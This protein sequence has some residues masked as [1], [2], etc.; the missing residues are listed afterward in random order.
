MDPSTSS[1]LKN[2]RFSFPQ[3]L[4]TAHS[5]LILGGAQRSSTSSMLGFQ[6]AW[7][8]ADDPRCCERVSHSHVMSRKQAFHSTLPYPVILHSFHEFPRA[9][10]RVNA[11]VLFTAEPSL[12]Q[13]SP[14]PRLGL[15]LTLGPQRP[16]DAILIPAFLISFALCELSV[17]SRILFNF[18][19]LSLILW[20]TCLPSLVWG[21]ISNSD[22]AVSY[23]VNKK[24]KKVQ[25]IN[26][27]PH[28]S[29][30]DSEA[31]PTIAPC[32]KINTVF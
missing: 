15:V 32:L 19:M 22:V 14:G 18:L 21:L 17:E 31:A 29:Y 10:V 6:G 8:C 25:R 30:L 16:W 9:L 23:R 24:K 27:I 7:P 5:S 1:V 12:S 13:S 11:D 4:P 26:A 3:E 28:S 20:S 2:K